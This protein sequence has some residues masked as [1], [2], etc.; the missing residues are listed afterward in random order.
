VAQRGRPR[1]RGP[2]EPRRY[3]YREGKKTVSATVT[4]EKWKTL[5]HLVTETERTA[6]DLLAEAIDDLAVKYRARRQPKAKRRGL[7]PG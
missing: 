2:D 7:D 6:N 4:V 3:P 5:R 1:S